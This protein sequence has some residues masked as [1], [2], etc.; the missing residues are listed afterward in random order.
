MTISLADLQQLIRVMYLDKDA[1]RGIDGT[2]MWLMEE[3]GE[4]ATALREG[5]QQEKMEELADVL[6]AASPLPALS[7]GNVLAFANAGAYGLWSSP[8]LFHASPLP[9]EVAFDGTMLEPMR[10]PQSA[11]SILDGQNHVVRAGSRS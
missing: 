6:A 2:F 4:L 3:I 10:H 5:T 11:R 7:P 8:V 9:A 1:A